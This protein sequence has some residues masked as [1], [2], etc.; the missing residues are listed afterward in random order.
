MRSLDHASVRSVIDEND[1]LP[2][3]V[4]APS[5]PSDYD[6]YYHEVTGANV[7]DLLNARTVEREYGET[8]GLD[9]ERIYNDIDEVAEEVEDF[10]W[11]SYRLAN[12]A[13]DFATWIPIYRP[14]AKMM[15]E[16]MPWKKF[17]VIDCY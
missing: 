12:E 13:I 8:Y 7:V 6:T 5:T 1:S 10:L 15:A 17:V 4:L 2:L 11:D 14:I 9:P 3:I 16:D